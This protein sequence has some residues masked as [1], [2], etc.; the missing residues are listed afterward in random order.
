MIVTAKKPSRKRP[1]KPRQTVQPVA[2]I[3]SR[4]KPGKRGTAPPAAAL[5]DDSEADASVR[6]FLT[7][8]IRPPD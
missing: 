2:T 3:V 1:R 5:P 8:M 7:R 4:P 6:D